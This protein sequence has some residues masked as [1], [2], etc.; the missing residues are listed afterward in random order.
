[1][2]AAMLRLAARFFVPGVLASL[3]L[4]SVGCGGARGEGEGTTGEDLALSPNAQTA[5]EYFVGQGLTPSQSAGIVGNL[6]QESNIDPT[7]LQ[8]GGGPGRGIAQWSAGGRWDTDSGDNVVAYAQQQGQSEWSLSLQLDFIW[9][10]L[11][12]FSHY[13]LAS[14][15]ASSDVTSA[16]IAFQN[17]F[18]GCGACAQSTR[19]A[20]AKAVLAAYGNGGGSS[21]GGSSGGSGSGSS[22]GSSSGSS[23][24]SSGGSSSGGGGAGCYSSTLGQD[25]PDN[26]CVQSRHDGNWYQCDNGTWVDRWTD[27]T[28]CNGEYPLN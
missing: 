7:I 3:S 24:G 4:V 25:M 1:M 16:T 22:G 8:Y 11:Q 15:E 13:G 17:D 2:R 9:F 19:I 14:L 5:Y 10:E 20:Y 21:S 26:A 12:N 6:E 28:A 18:E 27:P 23:G